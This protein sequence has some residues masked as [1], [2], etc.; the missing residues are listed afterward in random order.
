M[1]DRKILDH[2]TKPPLLPMPSLVSHPSPPT[3]PPTQKDHTS[4]IAAFKKHLQWAESV[5][6][7]GRSLATAIS[8]AEAQMKN[9]QRSVVVAADNLDNHVVTFQ[10]RLHDRQEDASNILRNQE[11]VFNNWENSVRI[12]SQV[13]LHPGFVNIAQRQANT[14]RGSAALADLVNVG[15]L[16]KA[17]AVSELKAQEFVN[18]M[19][20]VRAEVEDIVKRNTSLRDDIQRAS[21]GSSGNYQSDE[22]QNIL[23]DMEAMTKRLHGGKEGCTYHVGPE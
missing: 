8:T 16:K 6:A 4:W 11:E 21:V 1:F 9:I 17:Q 23:E 13:T 12:A 15:E 20:N 2:N 7:K 3:E 5:L 22:P 18:N 19:E 14:S 10:K